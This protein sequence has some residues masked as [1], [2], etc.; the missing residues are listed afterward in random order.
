MK[1]ILL[2]LFPVF[3][4]GQNKWYAT[5]KN[6]LI[7]MGIELIAGYG[8]GWREEIIQHPKKFMEAHPGWNVPFWDNRHQGNKGILNMEWNADHVLKGGI[9]SLHVI[10][11]VFKIGGGKQNWKKYLFDAGKFYGSYKAGFFL[12]YNITHKNKL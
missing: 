12:A 9:T 6:D 7:I 11:I 4:F 5:S 10:A 2:I 8:Q 1:V 3:C